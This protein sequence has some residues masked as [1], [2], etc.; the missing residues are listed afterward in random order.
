MAALAGSGHGSQA[1]STVQNTTAGSTERTAAS[2]VHA[3]AAHHTFQRN[4]Y[5]IFICFEL[6][7]QEFYI[8]KQ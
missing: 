2:D 3:R 4:V 5:I 7:K 6:Y 1:G 8:M